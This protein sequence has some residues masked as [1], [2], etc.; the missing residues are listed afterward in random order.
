MKSIYKD[1]GVFIQI[2]LLI[3]LAILCILTVWIKELEPLLELVI[4]LLLIVTGINNHHR[5][6]RKFFTVIYIVCGISLIIF[7]I[8]SV[9][10]NGI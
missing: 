9:V 5:Y 2:V 1:L 6:K 7:T 3:V 4:G 10:I 8:C